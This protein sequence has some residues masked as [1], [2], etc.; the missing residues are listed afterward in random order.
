M[1]ILVTDGESRSALAVTRSLGR[2]GYNISVA[3]G[4]LKNISASSKFCRQAFKTP[5]PLN[6]PRGY[7]K[8]IIDI[9]HREHIDILFPITETSIYCLN[10]VRGQ[11]G[12][13]V[14]MACASSDKME[15]VSNK[16]NLFQMADK[17][18]VAIPETIYVADTADFEKKKKQISAF[19]VVVKPS[20]S[21]IEVV[22]RIIS[23]KV[24][25][26][27]SYSELSRLYE[28][29]PELK[30][31]SMIQ[32]MIVGKG[33]GLFTLFDQDR[34]LALFS[35]RRILE[36][37]PWGGVSVLS[38]SIPLE[39]DMVE[40]SRRLL[41]AV[42]WQGIAMVE[43]KRDERNGKA[44]LMEVNGRFWGS[45]QLAVSSGVDF[46]SLNLDYHFNRK[47]TTV[48]VDYS[49]GHKLKWNL[50]ILD[51]LIIRIKSG[52]QL[53]DQYAHIPTRWQVVKEIL[54]F[55]LKNTSFDVCD[56]KDM[57]PF[58]CELYGYLKDVN[59]KHRPVGNV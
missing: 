59:R 28:T 48:L 14:I 52:E 23:T 7:T 40:A 24:M 3:G 13:S 46:P 29:K 49:V 33:T 32:E 16:Y 6:D 31:P 26:A 55:K 54:N 34:H 39:D 25:Y 36:K 2:R 37:P 38:E 22:D 9:A 21:K 50:G 47:P 20:Y 42:G 1:N 12:N 4:E 41:S 51:H 43:F 18:G 10:K 44:I 35:H 11:I 45:L 8:A 27:V 57:R 53:I 56:F 58:L 30:Y 17:L 19:P 5:N 15:S